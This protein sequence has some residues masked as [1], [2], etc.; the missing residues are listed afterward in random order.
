M[1]CTSELRFS[2]V[3]ERDLHYIQHAQEETATRRCCKGGGRPSFLGSRPVVPGA[4]VQRNRYEAPP[5]FC[6]LRDAW[7]THRLEKLPEGQLVPSCGTPPT[8]THREISRKRKASV[9]Q[10]ELSM[11][12]VVHPQK[13]GPKRGSCVLCAREI[14]ER[15]PDF[16]SE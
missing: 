9:N 1:C 6:F 15:I 12:R 4:E 3:Y 8:H 11:S 13:R 2:L 10:I 14:G 5:P 16:Q 7:P